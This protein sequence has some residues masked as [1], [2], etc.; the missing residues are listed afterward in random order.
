MGVFFDVHNGTD[1]TVS[2]LAVDLH[3]LSGQQLLG[4]DNSCRLAV[5]IP[6]GQ[7]ARLGCYKRV[8]SGSTGVSPQVV[9]VRWR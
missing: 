4:T 3:Y 5:N 6:P 1:T 7:T 8:V 9:D 2:E